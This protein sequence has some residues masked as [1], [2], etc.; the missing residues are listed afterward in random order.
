MCKSD[1][2]NIFLMIKSII[3]K[4]IQL[5]LVKVQNNE[6]TVYSVSFLS[7]SVIN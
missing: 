1:V 5:F 2:N 3:K 6:E 7:D 4:K